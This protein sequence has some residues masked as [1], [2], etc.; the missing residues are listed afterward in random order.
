MA[1]NSII[2]MYACMYV[3]TY[4]CIYECVCVLASSM[5]RD[6]G[7]LDGCTVHCIVMHVYHLRTICI[8]CVNQACCMRNICY[9]CRNSYVHDIHAYIMNIYVYSMCKHYMYVYHVY[10]HHA[11]NLNV[12][13]THDAHVYTKHCVFKHFIR[14]CTT[15][16][17]VL[18]A[19][20]C[21][22]LCTLTRK[23][24]K[25]CNSGCGQKTETRQVTAGK[26]SHRS[27]WTEHT[28]HFRL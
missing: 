1:V 14:V 25:Q 12:T 15:G 27:C 11:Y 23:C 28:C 21:S 13:K 24:G 16:C 10:V 26:S 3:C 18:I 22:P 19:Q 9:V 20:A 5:G 8:L 4:V 17:N 6:S 2:R 7:T